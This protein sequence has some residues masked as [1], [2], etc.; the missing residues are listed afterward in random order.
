MRLFHFPVAEESTAERVL[1][2]SVRTFLECE[3]ESGGFVPGPD[4]WVSGVSPDFSRK[5]GRQGWIG[6]TWPKAYGGH[7]RPA[8]DRFVVTEELLVA[9]APVAAHWIADRQSGGQVLAYGTEEQKRSILP[10]IAAGE[11]Y[12]SVGMSE[13]QAGSDL[14][15]IQTRATRTLTGWLLQGR[16]IWSTGAHIAGYMIVLARTS[17]A[18]GKNRH[19]GLSQFLVDLSLSG[20]DVSGIRDMAG[21]AHFNEVVFDGVELPGDTLLGKEGDGWAQCMRE[22]AMER[23]GPERFLTTFILLE[24]ALEAIRDQISP[25]VLGDLIARLVTLRAMSRGIALRLQKGENPGTEAVI[26]KQLGNVFEKHLFSAIRSAIAI[27]PE[28]DIRDDLLSLR[29]EAQLRLPSHSLRGGTTEILRG[30][31]ARQLGVR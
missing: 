11:C 18:E 5:L 28:A 7:D 26:V 24:K 10:R 29:D 1:R 12:F 15:A 22:L 30:V 21:A 19:V 27:G 16:K 9:G 6:M 13:P 31:I 4:C 25:I 20:I 2:S 23:S 17:P 3:R 8:L 14:A